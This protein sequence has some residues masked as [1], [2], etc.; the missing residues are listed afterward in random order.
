MELPLASGSRH[1]VSPIETAA[2]REVFPS[3][4]RNPSFVLRQRFAHAAANATTVFRKRRAS[5]PSVLPS[6]NDSIPEASVVPVGPQAFPGRLE[7]VPATV[8][9][10][11]VRRKTS[12][13]LKWHGVPGRTRASSLVSPLS[14][15]PIME[16]CDSNATVTPMTV[17]SGV[18]Y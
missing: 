17:Q 7:D 1:S 18:A 9:S 14:T 8:P 12:F 13:T 4:K 15:P 5:D 11:P 2:P 10:K 16:A 6:A 3:R